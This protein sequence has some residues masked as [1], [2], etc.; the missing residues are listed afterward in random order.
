M[1][2][3]T[4]IWEG[5]KNG[6]QEYLGLI[7]K[8]YYQELF[9]YGV[10]VLA[11]EEVVKETIQDLF[12]KLWEKR[13]SIKGIQSPK[14]YLFK[15]LRNLLIDKLRNNAQSK[16]TWLHHDNL[17]GYQISVEEAI[18]REEKST[19]QRLQI[20]QAIDKLTPLQ[21]EIIY[22]KFYNQ[23]EYREIATIINVNYQTVRNYMSKAV[24]SLRTEIQRME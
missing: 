10:K 15:M 17:T 16:A 11:D 6:N 22:L 14:G 5:F 3:E 24:K 2:S 8:T 21:Q 20:Q 19:D 7:F 9:L 18:I 1:S 12:I 13:A 23:L 4:K